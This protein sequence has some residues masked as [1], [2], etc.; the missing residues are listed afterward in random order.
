MP[1]IVEKND[2][3]LFEMFYKDFTLQWKFRAT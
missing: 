1:K 2:L 3:N